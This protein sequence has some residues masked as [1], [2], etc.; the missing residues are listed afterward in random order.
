M[1]QQLTLEDMA[2]R[3]LA[4][5]PSPSHQHDPST[6]KRAA[7]ANTPRSGSQRARVLAA[8]HA[9]GEYGATDYELGKTLG[10]LRTAAGT[11]R[12]DLERDGLVKRTNRERET[13][14]PGS[15]AQVHVLTE[16]GEAVA[17]KLAQ[18]PA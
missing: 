17:R 12:G 10:I 16:A 13:D 18:V 5:R 8:L 3:V 1:G 6:S 14:T 7:R 4:P 15:M 2:E 11:R 9:A